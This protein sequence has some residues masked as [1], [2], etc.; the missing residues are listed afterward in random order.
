[1][2]GSK[3]I[4]DGDGSVVVHPVVPDA[5]MITPPVRPPLVIREIH[6]SR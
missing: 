3:W 2:D 1:M 4:V 5:I 6:S